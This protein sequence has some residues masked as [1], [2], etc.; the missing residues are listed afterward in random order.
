VQQQ[1]AQRIAVVPVQAEEPV[2]IAALRV[3]TEPV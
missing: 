1:Y 3:L 2:G